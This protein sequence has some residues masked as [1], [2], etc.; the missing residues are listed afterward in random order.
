MRIEILAAVAFVLPMVAAAQDAAPLFPSDLLQSIQGKWLAEKNM[1]AVEIVGRNVI[2]RTNSQFSGSL[3]S[4][5]SPGTTVATL[6][7]ED[8]SRRSERFRF[9][10]GMCI[11][12]STN[13]TP[14][15]CTIMLNISQPI[16]DGPWKINLT[17]RDRYWKDGE[18]TDFTREHRMRKPG[19]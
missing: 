7:E 4:K 17:I 13:N 3:Y 9:I 6:G 5:I 12:A 11:D 1:E 19:G 10:K 16:T 14:S 18:L 8:V 2:L 15:P